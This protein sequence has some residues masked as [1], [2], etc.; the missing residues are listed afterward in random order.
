[1]ILSETP[2]SSEPTLI[3]DMSNLAIV[4]AASKSTISTAA[5]EQEDSTALN[6]QETVS[7]LPSPIK[8]AQAQAQ[9]PAKPEQLNNEETSEESTQDTTMLDTEESGS[10]H[11]SDDEIPHDGGSN[12]WKAIRLKKDEVERYE[13]KIE[14]ELKGDKLGK[15]RRLNM[16]RVI[17]AQ[18]IEAR[19]VFLRKQAEV[20]RQG[21][22]AR[23]GW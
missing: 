3:S 21:R 11:S 19:D 13:A 7:T 5:L 10:D 4:A 1:M 6:S 9:V 18:Q 12:L 23:W 14:E 15:E 22:Y 17:L 2:T 20:D 16:L 8:E